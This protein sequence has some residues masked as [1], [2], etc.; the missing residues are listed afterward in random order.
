M[1]NI[2]PPNE[3]EELRK[4]ASELWQSC[5]PEANRVA[6]EAV[7]QTFDR[8]WDSTEPSLVGKTG[9]WVRIVEIP[10]DQMGM[11]CRATGTRYV[12]DKAVLVL[13]RTLIL[14]PLHAVMLSELEDFL[15]K[16]A[17]ASAFYVVEP[18]IAFKDGDKPYI[19]VDFCAGDLI[20]ASDL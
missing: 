7:N 15:K 10:K 17:G 14:C 6:R 2:Q 12:G 9:H 19:Q 3:I 16:T 13:S 20:T 11:R 18:E 5:I 1:D 4:R 8:I